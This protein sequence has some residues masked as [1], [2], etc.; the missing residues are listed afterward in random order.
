[1][2]M[3]RRA[4]DIGCAAGILVAALLI[5]LVIFATWLLALALEGGTRVVRGVSAAGR[6]ARRAWPF[7]RGGVVSPVVEH[8]ARPRRP[9]TVWER[10]SRRWGV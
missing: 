5:L 8:D 10:M 6:L 1:M 3:E 2:S 7:E 4:K 9:L